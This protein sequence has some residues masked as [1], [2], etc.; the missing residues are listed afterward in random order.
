LHLQAEAH[1]CGLGT[2]IEMTAAIEAQPQPWQTKLYV[3]RIPLCR[4]LDLG[5]DPQE[6]P[7]EAL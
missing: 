5:R 2:T 6:I 1:R 3:H 7:I 4:E